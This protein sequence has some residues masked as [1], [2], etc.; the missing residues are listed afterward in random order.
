MDSKCSWA[1]NHTHTHTHT[2]P[3]AHMH[4]HS[5]SD[6][7]L[8]LVHFSSSVL[9]LQP[10]MLTPGEN[11]SGLGPWKV[12]LMNWVLGL[13]RHCEWCSHAGLMRV[14]AGKIRGR[15]DRSEKLSVVSHPDCLEVICS[16]VLL[17]PWW[18]M[19]LNICQYLSSLFGLSLVLLETQQEK[20][21]P[22]NFFTFCH[23]LSTDFN[24][25]VLSRLYQDTAN[26]NVW[27]NHWIDKWS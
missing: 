2:K 6:S 11:G 20:E 22:L 7:P 18:F 16:S 24:K 17:E 8:S 4:K 15:W 12:F 5:H 14:S 13:R 23:A 19:I 25:F 9:A 10:V 21:L 1:G 27:I 26:R 3:H